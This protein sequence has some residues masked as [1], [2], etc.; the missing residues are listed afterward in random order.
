MTV[1][2][3]SNILKQFKPNT[4]VEIR[5]WDWTSDIHLI[6]EINTVIKSPEGKII[7]NDKHYNGRYDPNNNRFQYT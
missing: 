1:K 6:R 4:E 2:E 7:I 3:L 5:I